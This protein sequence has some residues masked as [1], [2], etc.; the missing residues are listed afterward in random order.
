MWRTG[1][2][3]RRP[4]PARAF[5]STRSATA[6]PASRRSSSIVYSEGVAKGR[7]T[8]ERMVDLLATTPAR[9]F[10]LATKGALEVGRDADL[11]L[12]DPAARRT[13]RA[14]D[15]HHTSDYTPYEGLEVTGAVRQRLRPRP[16]GHPRRRLRRPT[17]RGAFVERGRSATDRQ[18]PSPSY[19]VHWHIEQRSA[20]APRSSINREGGPRDRGRARPI[21]AA[22]RPAASGTPRNRRRGRGDRAGRPPRDRRPFAGAAEPGQLLVADRGVER[23][24]ERRRPSASGDA[25]RPPV[26]ELRAR[27]LGGRGVLHQVVD[28][29]RADRRAARNRGTRARPG[30]WPGR[31]AS[32]TAPPGTRRSSSS[33]ALTDDL[34][35]QPILLVRPVAEHAIEDLRRD[36][37]EVRMRDPRAVEA[38]AATRAPCRRGPW[39]ARPR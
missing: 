14:A 36:R 35:A 24:V 30:C 21:P 22:S 33:A 31:P 26:P 9:R 8:V 34:V 23:L 27:D 32:V 2:A 16:A 18:A 37:D 7:I 25:A 1:W 28:G 13:I 17:R 19:A 12:F 10:G 3:S 20:K 11:V 38:V 4:R 6:R 39:P 29:G 15:L 5:P